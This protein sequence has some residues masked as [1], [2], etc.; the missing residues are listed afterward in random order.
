[1]KKW[2]NGGGL[3]GGKDGNV[4]AW[5]H[6]TPHHTTP[7]RT[8]PNHTTLHYTILHY[9]TLHY[10]TLHYTTLHYTT[11]HYTTLHYTTLHY[12]TPLHHCSPRTYWPFHSIPIIRIEIKVSNRVIIRWQNLQMKL[13]HSGQELLKYVNIPWSREGKEWEMKTEIIRWFSEFYAVNIF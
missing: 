7:H 12:T 2:R 3:D 8:T 5:H 13:Y 9:T 4:M 1:M 10:T 6:I 11:L